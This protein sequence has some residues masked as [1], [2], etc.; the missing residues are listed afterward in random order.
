M[1]TNSMLVE[2]GYATSQSGITSFQRDYNRFASRPL[3]VTGTLDAETTE[4]VA[5]AFEARVV[6]LRIREANKEGGG[7]R[8]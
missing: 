6:F 1:S 5:F 7:R 8:A 4:A 2:L 3:V